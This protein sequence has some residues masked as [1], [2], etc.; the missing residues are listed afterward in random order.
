[1]RE[2]KIPIALALTALSGLQE[3]DAKFLAGVVQAMSAFPAA[4]RRRIAT[5]LVKLCGAD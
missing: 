5:A 2:T 1:M 3:D 4:Q